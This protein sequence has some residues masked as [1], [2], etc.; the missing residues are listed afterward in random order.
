MGF[1]EKRL[2]TGMWRQI[3]AT[4]RSTRAALLFGVVA[5]ASPHADADAPAN[6]PK[7]GPS[8]SAASGT[9]ILTPDGN[10]AGRAKVALAI[11]GAQLN[12]LNGDDIFELAGIERRQADAAGRFDFPLVTGNSLLVVTHSSGFAEVKCSPVSIPQP[13]R[14]TPWARV[15]G[16]YRVARKPRPHVKI[17]IYPNSV[18]GAFNAPARAFFRSE[19]RTDTN[20]R[21]VFERVVPGALRI[22]HTLAFSATDGASEI[23]SGGFVPISLTAGQTRQVDLGTRGRPVI[24]Q[25]RRPTGAT[26]EV[27][28]KFAFVAVSSDHRLPG[29]LD[30]NFSATLDPA[31][32]FCVD[33]VPTGKHVLSV[34]F[35]KGR[36]YILNHPFEVP[37]I[38]EKLSQRPVDLGVLKLS[39]GGRW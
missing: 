36:Q 5:L 1:S 28:W 14:L 39:V 6:S 35:Y 22:G 15:E 2:P 17:E 12:I 8:K 7:N 16:T 32:N 37:A 38:N 29:A 9:T 25:L 13:I 23:A 33:D 20:G 3:A 19:Q 30:L 10:P 24:G 26:N 31:G 27:P 21:F 11:Q 4:Q 34:F 18:F